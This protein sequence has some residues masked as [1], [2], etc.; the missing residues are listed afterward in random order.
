[1]L[2]GGVA[3]TDDTEL[4]EYVEGED[5]GDAFELDE[6]ELSIGCVGAGC[7]VWRRGESG[8][9]VVEDMGRVD[10]GRCSG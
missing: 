3:S 2:V 6:Y 1:M 7:L 8:C 4:T 10:G 9:G 5:V